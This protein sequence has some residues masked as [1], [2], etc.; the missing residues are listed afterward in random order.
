MLDICLLGTGGMMP[1][2][3]RFL[4]SLYVKYQGHAV[5][6][7]CGEG[8]QTAIRCAEVS[9]KDID[10][11]C[12]TH[13]HADH[14][15]GLP[16]LLL[17]IGNSGRTEPVLVA[18]PEGLEEVLCSLCIIAPE[19]PF[20][21][22]VQ[23]EDTPILLGDLSIKS[24]PTEH[25]I[26]CRGYVFELPRAGKFSVES[27]ESLGIP[28]NLWS[29]LQHGETVTF[30]GRT[31]TPGQVLGPPRKGLKVLYATD[32]RPVPAISKYGQKADLMILEGIYPEEEK[33]G[34]AIERGHMLYREAAEMALQ[35]QAK[36]LWLTHFSPAIPNPQ[37]QIDVAKSIFP[38]VTAGKDG[39]KKT[40]Y[41]SE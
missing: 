28:K 30:D 5:L 4:T 12:I 16:G 41:F 36:E 6:I 39:M 18:G 3:K 35:S 17:T 19:L 23:T 22:Y 34:K 15:A 20:D 11:I 33:L 13:F 26:P 32:T 9:M 1:L 38:Q 25:R 31:V 40:L 27:A 37:E 29:K 8:T 2:P 14:V 10:V 21:V 24:F 7:D